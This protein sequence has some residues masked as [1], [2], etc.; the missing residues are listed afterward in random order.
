MMIGFLY[1]F[2]SVIGF[3]LLVTENVFY[4][5]VY[6]LL[7]MLIGVL[8]YGVMLLITKTEEAKIVLRKILKRKKA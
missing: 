8:G 6:L 1:A 7:S 2:K 3:K 4:Q 5:I